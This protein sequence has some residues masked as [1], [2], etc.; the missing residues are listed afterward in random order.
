M[1]VR[2]RPAPWQ[3]HCAQ[4][5]P[6]PPSPDPATATLDTAVMCHSDSLASIVYY[7]I[8]ITIIIISIQIVIFL[9]WLKKTHFQHKIR[10]K[11]YFKNAHNIVN[12]Y[13]TV[14]S[15]LVSVW[16]EILVK[17]TSVLARPFVFWSLGA[18]ILGA[19]FLVLNN[20]RVDT[21][22]I[23]LTVK[24]CFPLKWFSSRSL[25]PIKRRDV[26]QFSYLPTLW[27]YSLVSGHDARIFAFPII[28]WP[29]FKIGVEL[30]MFKVL[31]WVD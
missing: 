22:D 5:P 13:R 8:I 9:F 24:R 11:R 28:K 21:R 12:N 16:N 6:P 31:E 7:Y 14:K 15:R 29:F 25:G 4:P 20:G 19:R 23:K 3:C 10:E 2:L 30:N 26:V 27:W 17:Q 1:C 18:A